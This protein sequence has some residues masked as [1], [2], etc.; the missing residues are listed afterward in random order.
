MDAVKQ[1]FLAF[2]DRTSAYSF[3][4]IIGLIKFRREE[5]KFHEFTETVGVFMVILY[6]NYHKN[7]TIWENQDVFFLSEC[8]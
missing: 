3:H 1:L 6:I 5:T 7:K 2:T 4:H 8:K